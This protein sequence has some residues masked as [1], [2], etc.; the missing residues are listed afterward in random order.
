MTTHAP[1]FSKTKTSLFFLI[2][3]ISLFTFWLLVLTINVYSF[4]LVGVVYELLWLPMLASL[5]IIPIWSF[6]R[7][8]KENFN[9]RSFY[10][11]SIL[12]II[13]TALMIYFIS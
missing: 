9:L 2:W 11:Y 10:F 3:T 4:I 12:G 6:I 13:L 7:W 8:R 1:L 5:L